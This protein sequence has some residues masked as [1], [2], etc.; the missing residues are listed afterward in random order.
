MT[1]VEMIRSLDTRWLLAVLLL[2]IDIW[3]I[4]LI[5]RARAGRRETAL[6]TFVVLLVPVFGCIFWYALGP[7]PGPGLSDGGAAQ[8]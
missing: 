6:W 1:I 5:F 4:G 3:S 2:A 7:K 8:T